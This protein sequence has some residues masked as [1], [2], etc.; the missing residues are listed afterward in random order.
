[1]D[2]EALVNRPFCNWVKIT[3]TLSK[4]AKLA[5]HHKALQDAD[6]LKS[7]IDNPKSRIDILSSSVLQSRVK[8]NKHIFGQIVHAILYL[9]KQGL[10]LRGHRENLGEESNPGNFLKFLHK[11]M[12]FFHLTWKSLGPK[13][14]H[15]CH[16][17]PRMRS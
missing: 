13:M 3:E 10:A 2:K 9:T 8:E 17:H 16:H 15:T 12:K 14:L 7:V 1:M 5:Y 4:H 6:I 11:L